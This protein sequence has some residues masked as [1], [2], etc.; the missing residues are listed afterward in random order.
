MKGLK[1][2][3]ENGAHHHGPPRCWRTV[4]RRGAAQRQCSTVGLD[5]AE[6]PW[7]TGVGEAGCDGR[8]EQPRH[9]RAG[10]PDG[11]PLGCVPSPHQK[12]HETTR[13]RAPWPW[14]VAAHSAPT[15]WVPAGCARRSHAAA[16]GRGDTGRLTN[17]GGGGRAPAHD[18]RRGWMNN[19]GAW[20]VLNHAGLLRC[21]PSDVKRGGTTHVGER[22]GAAP[23]CHCTCQ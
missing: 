13:V 5:G 1:D 18:G 9:G 14:R 19:R 4:S 12:R 20:Q 22:R 21:G 3:K 16:S 15:A 8:C 11:G 6:R 2:V 17:D 10:V 23:C 7:R